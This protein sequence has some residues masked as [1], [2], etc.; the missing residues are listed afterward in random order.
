[1]ILISKRPV[2]TQSPLQTTL[3]DVIKGKALR[4]TPYL[5][6]I[7]YISLAHFVWFNSGMLSVY[8]R[9]ITGMF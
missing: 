7:D 3:D 6:D 2:A 9:D 5:K 4:N 1:V 8:I